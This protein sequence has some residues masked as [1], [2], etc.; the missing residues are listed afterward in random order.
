[1]VDPLIKDP[2]LSLQRLGSLL[3]SSF[4][5]WPQELL[6]ATDTAKKQTDKQINKN[7]KGKKLKQTTDQEMIFLIYVSNRRLTKNF[8]KSSQAI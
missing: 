1:M 2:A 7:K 3:W 5:P 4:K 6:L 8:Q